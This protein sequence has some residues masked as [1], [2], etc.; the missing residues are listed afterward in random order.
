M[1]AR[2]KLIIIP[3]I[4]VDY[5]IHYKNITFSVDSG[6]PGSEISNIEAIIKNKEWKIPI[7]LRQGML[8]EA[9]LEIQAIFELQKRST[10]KQG[11]YYLLTFM[12]ASVVRW[13]IWEI[14]P[15]LAL[16]IRSL[17]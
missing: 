12:P 15:R 5:R 17:K 9:R 14:R 6:K 10:A 1:N 8:K 3:E 16:F 7:Y 13:L 4:L 2:S 11:L